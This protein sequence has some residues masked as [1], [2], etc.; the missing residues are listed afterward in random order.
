MH[1]IEAKMLSAESGH[2]THSAGRIGLWD[3][4]RSSE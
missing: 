1:E 3:N 4:V 2:V